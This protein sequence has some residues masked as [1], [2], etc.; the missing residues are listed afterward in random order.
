MCAVSGRGGWRYGAFFGGD[1]ERDGAL[2]GE[3]SGRPLCVDEM[4][5]LS[6][7]TMRI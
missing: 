5:A 3:S 6:S 7:P 4:V 2:H 1:W